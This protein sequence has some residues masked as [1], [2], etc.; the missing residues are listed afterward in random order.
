MP[1]TLAHAAVSIP[2]YHVHRRWISFSA[3][4]IG[5]IT[6]DFEYFLRMRMLSEHSHLVSGM[7]YFNLP[8]GFL[9]FVFFEKV[10]K[11]K[12]FTSAQPPSWRDIGA[13]LPF[14]IFSLLIG[15]GS[16]L[17]WD[18]FTHATGFFVECFSF[19]QSSIALG[20]FEVPVYKV[21]QHASS[22]IGIAAVAGFYIKNFRRRI[23]VGNGNFW[24]VV[25]AI[26]FLL[27]I[28]R[29]AFRMNE[30]AVGNIIVTAIAG[31][32]LG[33]VVSTLTLNNKSRAASPTLPS[34][35]SQDSSTLSGGSGNRQK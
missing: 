12:I 7:F 4:A 25:C 20:Y 22:V 15:I 24:L 26:A 18:S 33:V 32:L 6:P 10:L 11:E 27:T 13:R 8:I 5:T 19:L 16:H 30:L 29:F 34:N 23:K 28:L 21:L 31:L 9:L 14:I 35:S 3:I 2:F 1:F 17:L